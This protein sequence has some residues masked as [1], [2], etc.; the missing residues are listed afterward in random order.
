MVRELES[1]NNILREEVVRLR[2]LTDEQ[3]RLHEQGTRA[4][5]S[6]TADMAMKQSATESVVREL[7]SRNDILRQEVVRL[8]GLTDEQSALQEQ[9][10]QELYIQG[11]L[12]KAACVEIQKRPVIQEVSVST[13][14]A[15]QEEMAR[16]R[17]CNEEQFES[18][19]ERLESLASE[20]ARCKMLFETLAKRQSALFSAL[21]RAPAAPVTGT[22]ATEKSLRKVECPMK[23]AKSLEGIISYLKK[24]SGG[25]VHERGIVTM[26]SK[27]VTSEDPEYGPSNC[28]DLTGESEFESKDE[29]GQWIC[30]DFHSRRVSVTDYTIWTGCVKSWVVEGSVDGT[31]WK[32]LD[33]RTDQKRL[34]P[35]SF[36]ISDV[37]VSGSSQYRFIRLTQ[38]EK[39]RYGSDILGLNAVEFFGALWE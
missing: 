1:Q 24:E 28:R 20:V 33:R 35:A 16:L 9:V 21:E 36:A 22:V 7:E 13:D 37:P 27:T 39:N 11:E 8:R 6:Q 34:T 3:N 29:A 17:Q 12:L 32:E 14:G 5:S 25:A 2:V 4:I 19:E 18:Q 30:W 26:T 38:I 31:N 15:V 23:E 10:R